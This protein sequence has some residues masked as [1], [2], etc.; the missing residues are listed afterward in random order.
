MVKES[1]EAFDAGAGAEAHD[2]SGVKT[3][4]DYGKDGSANTGEANA[5]CHVCSLDR[6]NVVMHHPAH[7]YRLNFCK[8]MLLSSTHS[9][10]VSAAA[11]RRPCMPPC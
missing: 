6:S 1:K 8:G 10:A 3:G 5:C 2:P 7:S 4:R 9:M 11:A